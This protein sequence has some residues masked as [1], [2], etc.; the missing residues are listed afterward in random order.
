MSMNVS[1]V[2]EKQKK[3]ELLATLL[4]DERKG[5]GK[6]IKETARKYIIKIAS[7][8]ITANLTLEWSRELLTVVERRTLG[9]A[10]VGERKVHGGFKPRVLLG[11]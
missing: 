8:C 5:R 11:D 10:A 6:Y 2:P 9:G 1:K 4:G 3:I 7:R